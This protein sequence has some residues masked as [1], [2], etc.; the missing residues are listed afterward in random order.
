M[1]LYYLD[2]SALVKKYR[3]ELGTNTIAELFSDKRDNEILLTSHLTV[4]EITS[5]ATRLRRGGSLAGGAYGTLLA[6][7]LW[8]VSLEMELRPIS[9]SVI[10]KAVRLTMDFPLRAPD[11]I[12]LATALEARDALLDETF[13]FVVSAGRL[14]SAGISADLTVL[15]P[16]EESAIETL[17]RFRS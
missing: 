11:A 9:D 16:E 4:V 5:V 7:L 15:D 13:Y 1:P 8:D 3:T 2:S 17:R 6:S 12:H 10:F 14:K